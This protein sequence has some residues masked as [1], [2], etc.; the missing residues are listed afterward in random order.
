M[1]KHPQNQTSNIHPSETGLGRFLFLQEFTLYKSY[2][3]RKMIL[4]K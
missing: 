1:Q 4:N 3:K 2:K